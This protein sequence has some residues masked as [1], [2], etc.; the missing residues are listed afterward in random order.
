MVCLCG[1]SRAAED[2]GGVFHGSWVSKG[3]SFQLCDG[4]AHAMPTFIYTLSLCSIS[5][6][7]VYQLSTLRLQFYQLTRTFAH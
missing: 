2:N 5:Y 3:Q 4:A 6:L 1:Y 7:L